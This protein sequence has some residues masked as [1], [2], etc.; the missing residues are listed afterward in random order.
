MARHV[1]DI[2]DRAT[3]AVPPQDK[4]EVFLY[5]IKKVEEYYGATKTREVYEKAMEVVPEERVKDIALRFADLETKLGE[6]DRARAIYTY[7]SQFC[8]PQTQIT[9]WRMWL[10]FEGR[11]GNKETFKEMKRIERSVQAEFAQVGIERMTDTI[12]MVAIV[13][14]MLLKYPSNL[15]MN[16]IE[17]I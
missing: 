1:M 5:Y 8:N 14:V 2:L 9:F 12:L 17:F 13:I 7:A 4:H 10:D 11:H 16:M 6:I 15:H 3:T